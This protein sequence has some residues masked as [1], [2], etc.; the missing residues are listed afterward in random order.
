MPQVPLTNLRRTLEQLKPL[1]TS[2]YSPSDRQTL[3]SQLA[4]T[5]R[6]LRALYPDHLSASQKY[7]LLQHLSLLE[8]QEITLADTTYLPDCPQW[9]AL[10]SALRAAIVDVLSEYSDT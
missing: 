8:Q 10:N 5:I 2:C 7:Q 1:S 3:R 4:T 9:R 6:N